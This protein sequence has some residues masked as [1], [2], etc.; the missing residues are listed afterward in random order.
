MELDRQSIDANSSNVTPCTANSQY[1]TTI[2]NMPNFLGEKWENRNSKKYYH[3]LCKV[4]RSEYHWNEK[5]KDLI[6]TAKHQVQCPS[7]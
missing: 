7:E 1:G 5:K 6:L 3:N 4:T 2:L